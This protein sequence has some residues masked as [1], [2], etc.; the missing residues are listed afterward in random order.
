MGHA[1][2]LV[3]AAGARGDLRALTRLRA[4]LTHD[5]VRHQNRTGK[6]LEDTLLKVSGV[7]WDLMGGSGRRFGQALADGE[8]S[9]AA[10]AA[11][12]DY[13]LHVTSAGTV[14]ARSARAK[15]R[16]ADRPV[17]GP[18]IRLLL[19]HAARAQRAPAGALAGTADRW[20]DNSPRVRSGKGG[21]RPSQE[22]P[23]VNPHW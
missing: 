19:S 16:R 14:P 4:N 7:I 15:N 6:I 1:A 20:K 13:R 8:R 5:R 21:A 10:L 12:G 22:H 2:P 3:R 23:P 9:P 17:M 11:L 18:L